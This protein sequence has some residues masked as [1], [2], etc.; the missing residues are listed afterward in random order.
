MGF[1]FCI[2]RDKNGE[3]IATVF[4]LES[5]VICVCLGFALPRFLIG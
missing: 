3:N 4:N 5:K 1:F 2:F